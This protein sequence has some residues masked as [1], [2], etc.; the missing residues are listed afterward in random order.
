MGFL[1]PQQTNTSLV[2]I[3]I[4]HGVILHTL[5]VHLDTWHKR[6]GA[7]PSNVQLNKELPSQF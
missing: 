3:G 1:M 4:L 2:S 5:E 7:T 6:I